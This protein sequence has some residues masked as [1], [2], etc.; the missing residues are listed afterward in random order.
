MANLSDS[1]HFACFNDYYT[2]AMAWAQITNLIPKDKIIWEACMLNSSLSK[3]PEY[4][5]DLGCTVV[6][7]TKW[8]CL[9]MRPH[10]F[11]M[12]VTNPPFETPL[13]KKILK[14]FVELDKPFIIIMNSMNTFSKYLR[15]IFKNN[16]EHLQI[17]TPEGK[18][19]FGK[20]LDG[21]VIPTNNCS[22]YCIYLCYK[23]NIETKKL[24]L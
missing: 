1:S 23:C 22:F 8:D 15:E 6:Y 11:D 7:D 24:W 21:E 20:L 13:K 12:I 9:T 3:S 18:I 16:M 4:L 19:N 2:P 5:Q 10:N 14:R 17:I